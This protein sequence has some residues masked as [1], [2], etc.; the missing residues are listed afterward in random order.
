[1]RIYIDGKLFDHIVD[2]TIFQGYALMVDE[3][4][5]AYSETVSD[6]NFISIIKE[7]EQ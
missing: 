7:P 4:E 3:Q 5:R 1:M 6:S 2:I